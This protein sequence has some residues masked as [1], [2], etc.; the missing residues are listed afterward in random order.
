MVSP[1]GQSHLAWVTAIFEVCLDVPNISA[2]R[3]LL[4]ELARV[5]PWGTAR[6]NS[7]SCRVPD[8]TPCAMSNFSCKGSSP[9]VP[10]S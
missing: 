8:V 9:Y 7:G 5:G 3:I 1:H 10:L 4:G 6:A 2:L